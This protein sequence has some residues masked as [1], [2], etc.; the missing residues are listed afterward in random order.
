M[1]FTKI[2][3]VTTRI[4]NREKHFTKYSQVKAGFYVL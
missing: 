2:D 3:R 1:T 4:L